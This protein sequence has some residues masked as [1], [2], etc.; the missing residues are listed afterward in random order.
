MIE[1]EKLIPSIIEIIKVIGPYA[2]AIVSTIFAY[3]QT[4]RL[5]SAQEKIALINKEKDL[6]IANLQNTYALK[7]EKEARNKDI[8]KRLIELY[9]PLYA[10]IESLVNN[11]IGL[12]FDTQSKEKIRNDINKYLLDDYI[13]MDIHARKLVLAE[14]IAL[15]Q[16]LGD[17]ELYKIAANFGH[18]IDETVASIDISGNKSGKEYVEKMRELQKEYGLLYV[19]FFYRIAREQQAANK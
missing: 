18:K 8:S 7:K 14:S 9:T 3:C 10:K 17:Q 13:K 2:V 5:A 16:I 1:L 12:I 4:K 11:Y 19:A 6:F 15:C